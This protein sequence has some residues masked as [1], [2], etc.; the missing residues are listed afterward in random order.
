MGSVRRSSTP[1]VYAL[2]PAPV[3]VAALL[4]QL[5][6]G[7]RIA[8]LPSRGYSQIDQVVSRIDVLGRY[9][10]IHSEMLSTM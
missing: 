6:I 2:A 4:Q 5:S 3:H 1:T 7:R 10:P 9:K 8:A